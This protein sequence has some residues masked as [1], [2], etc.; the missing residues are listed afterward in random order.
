[1]VHAE[2]VFVAGI[3]P[4]RTWMS[5]SFECVWWNACVHR[6]DFVYTLIQKNLGGGGGGKD[7]VRTHVNSREKSR[8]PEKILPRG[9]SN[10]Q[11]C[12][13]QDSEPNTPTTSYSGPW[14]WYKMVEVNGTCKH[15]RYNKIWL[16]SLCVMSNIKV[17]AMQDGRMD[18]HT[19]RH[20]S[21][22]RFVW[23]SYGSK[24]AQICLLC[25]CVKS[26]NHLHVPWC[27]CLTDQPMSAVT[28][29]P[30]LNSPEYNQTHQ[31]F[32]HW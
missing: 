7:G 1:M 20:N 2:C 30:D 19:D 28:D 9:G 3:H 15:G 16:K 24:S 23:Y 12:N 8:Q 17:F 5:G 27:Y 29:S 18:G 32:L 31:N 6:L 4:S 21:S 13:K 26:K 10:P 22:H 11:R 14:K 25:Q